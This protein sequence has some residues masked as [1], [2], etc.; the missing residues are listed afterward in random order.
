MRVDEV[1]AGRAPRWAWRELTPY[2]AGA[3][4]LLALVVLIAR[5]IL[6]PVHAVPSAAACAAAYAAARTHADTVS[7]DLLTYRDPR[8]RPPGRTQT[9]YRRTC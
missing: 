4:L 6:A 5:L 7:A 8:T 3:A 2:G 1:A 9:P